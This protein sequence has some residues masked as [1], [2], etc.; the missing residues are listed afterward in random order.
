MKTVNM[1]NVVQELGCEELDREGRKSEVYLL[2]LCSFLLISFK[3][4]K[5]MRIFKAD[6]VEARRKDNW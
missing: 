1:D 5:N 2:C 6:V 4:S 3:Y